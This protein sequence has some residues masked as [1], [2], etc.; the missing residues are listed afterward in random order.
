MTYAVLNLVFDWCEYQIDKAHTDL[1][2]DGETKVSMQ[3]LEAI[4]KLAVALSDV[5]KY[6]Q[7]GSCYVWR[8][9]QLRGNRL[10]CKSYLVAISLH[11]G[12]FPYGIFPICYCKKY[13]GPVPA[14]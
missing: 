2:K 3:Y 5:M 9:Y 6:N 13:L 11:I 10:S 12:N 8:V 4:R 14:S 1:V 7:K